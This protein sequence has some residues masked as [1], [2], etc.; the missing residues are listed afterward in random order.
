MKV[1][2]LKGKKFGKL[3]VIEQLLPKEKGYAKWICKCDCGGEKTV[4][5]GHL[6]KGDVKSCGCANVTHGHTRG[7][8]YTAEYNTWISMKDRCC[9][10]KNKRYDRYGGRGITVSNEWLNNFDVFYKDMGDKPTPKH[11]IDRINND[12]GYCKENCKWATDKE[13]ARNQSSN[14]MVLNL[15][16]GIFF[17]SINETVEAHNLNKNVFNGKLARGKIKDFI[18]I[19]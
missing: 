3:T 2:D 11:S 14:V 1:I 6:K 18:K 8:I 5:S 19:I 16:T 17:S 7:R 13:Q 4:Q 12:K 9:N 15:N 10:P